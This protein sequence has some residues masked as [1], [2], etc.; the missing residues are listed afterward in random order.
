MTHNSTF[1]LKSTVKPYK[2][3]VKPYK[4]KVKPCAVAT[5]RSAH[6]FVVLNHDAQ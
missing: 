3:K 6:H 2:R 4:R 1:R 5:N